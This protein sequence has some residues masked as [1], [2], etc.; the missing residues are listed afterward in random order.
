M[1]E[2]LY[3]VRVLVFKVYEGLHMSYILF[4]NNF[5][6]CHS[7]GRTTFDIVQCDILFFSEILDI[8]LSFS[9]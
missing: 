6:L 9:T 7:K 5:V 8:L 2:H 4:R 1:L 3:F